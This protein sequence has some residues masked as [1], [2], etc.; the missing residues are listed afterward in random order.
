MS[1][2]AF[3]ARGNSTRSSRIVSL[4]SF[5]VV[6]FGAHV[7]V[8]AFFNKVNP[9]IDATLD[10]VDH[11]FEVFRAG[12]LPSTSLHDS[13]Q[14]TAPIS[15]NCLVDFRGHATETEASIVDEIFNTKRLACPTIPAQ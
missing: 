1:T 10:R 9:V 8:A 4:D 12:A 11:I 13:V 3:I 15:S 2:E 7:F 14:D 5:D 6:I